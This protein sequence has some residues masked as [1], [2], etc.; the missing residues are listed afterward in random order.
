MR[1]IKV[2]TW[3]IFEIIGLGII[4]LGIILHAIIRNDNPIALTSAVCGITYTFIAGKG[5]PIC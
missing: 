1:N 3:N 4:L 5:N 2:G